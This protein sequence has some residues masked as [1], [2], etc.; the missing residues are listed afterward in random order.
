MPSMPIPVIICGGLNVG[1]TVNVN[2]ALPSWGVITRSEHDSIHA[3]WP[4]LV[5]TFIARS[6]KVRLLHVG[7]GVEG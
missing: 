1:A 3:F 7:V 4:K 6:G 5:W 2:G